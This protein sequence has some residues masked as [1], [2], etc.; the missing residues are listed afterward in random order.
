M[1]SCYMEVVF[2][3]EVVFNYF[4]KAGQHLNLVPMLFSVL[5]YIPTYS[6]IFLN[7]LLLFLYKDSI[8]P[9]YNILTKTTCIN[10]RIQ[11]WSENTY[12][13]NMLLTIIYYIN[14]KLLHGLY[15]IYEEAT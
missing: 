1:Y 8:V 7:I 12:K 15:I 6:F 13:N 4:A 9:T 3:V 5:I 11:R 14:I 10:Y 2:N